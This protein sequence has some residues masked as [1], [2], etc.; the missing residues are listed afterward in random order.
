[1]LINLNM[2]RTSSDDGGPRG[3]YLVVVFDHISEVVRD[4]Y[5]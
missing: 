1:M 4:P 3:Q 5:R 2:T